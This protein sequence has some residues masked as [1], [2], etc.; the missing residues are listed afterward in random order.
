MTH[1]IESP[2]VELTAEEAQERAE[3]MYS[4]N[5]RITTGLS[6]GRV[7][8]WDVAEACFEL[9]EE[10]GWTALHYDTLAEYLADPEV[11]MTKTVFYRLVS[12]YRETVVRRQIPKSTV[13]GIDYSKVEIVMGKVRTGEVDVE[14]ALSDAK[15]MGWRDLREEYWGPR[16]QKP[17]DQDGDSADAAGETEQEEGGDPDPSKPEPPDQDDDDDLPVED[18]TGVVEFDDADES[19]PAHISLEQ[20]AAARSLAHWVAQMLAALDVGKV[21]PALRDEGRAALVR[22][23]LAGLTDA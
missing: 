12:A 6:A 16:E 9:N 3:V 20:V 14:E 2:P 19:E 22:A 18:V 23:Q 5:Q 21:S 8:M 7:A 1:P 17:Q 15:E 10:N 11:S 13:Q 4:L